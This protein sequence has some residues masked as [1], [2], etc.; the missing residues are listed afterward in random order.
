M[1]RERSIILRPVVNP[2]NNAVFPGI[3]KCGFL[4]HAAVDDGAS[5]T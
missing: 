3:G 2:A 5:D 1:K 4:R